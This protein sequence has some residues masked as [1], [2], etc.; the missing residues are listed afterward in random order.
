MPCLLC[1]G[2]EETGDRALSFGSPDSNY[3]PGLSQVLV[4]PEGA[5]R[6]TRSRVLIPYDY[7]QPSAFTWAISQEPLR[8]FFQWSDEEGEASGYTSSVTVNSVQMGFVSVN[9]ADNNSDDD[10][11]RQIEAQDQTFR[12]RRKLWTTANRC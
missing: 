3:S 9:M 7:G 6:G 5:F 11:R 4:E 2:E 12:A 1:R 10:L 8:S